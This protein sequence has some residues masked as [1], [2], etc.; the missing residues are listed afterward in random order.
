MHLGD[1][2]IQGRSAR[3]QTYRIDA[4]KPVRI[5]VGGGLDVISRDAFFPAAPDKLARVVAVR[6][7]R[8]GE[9]AR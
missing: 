2:G 1:A 7:E 6:A 4:V 5:E 9:D 8:Y 3:R